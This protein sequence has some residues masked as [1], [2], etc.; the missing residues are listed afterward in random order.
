[1]IRQTAKKIGRTALAAFLCACLSACASGPA[2]PDGWAQAGDGVWTSGSQRYQL[3][4]QPYSGDLKALG[5]Q[6]VVNT[7]MATKHAKFVGSRPYPGCPGLGIILT[8]HVAGGTAP[9]VVQEIMSIREGRATTI[10]Y[11]RDASAADDPAATK[12]ITATTCHVGV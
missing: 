5:G 11:T 7:V 3:T 10:T 9:T 8:F 2:H 12:A 1:M 6:A 4:T